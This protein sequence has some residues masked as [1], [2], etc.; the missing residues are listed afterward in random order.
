MKSSEVLRLAAERIHTGKN[1]LSCTAI[2]KVAPV[3]EWWVYNELGSWY[4]ALFSPREKC[5]GYWLR[6]ACNEGLIAESDMLE[7]RIMALLFAAAIKESEG[8]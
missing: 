7:W 5:S 1:S 6:E 4:E 2:I 3:Y 8:D